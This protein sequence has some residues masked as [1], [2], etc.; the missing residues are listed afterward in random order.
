MAIILIVTDNSLRVVTEVHYPH[1]LWFFA[2]DE[3]LVNIMR[4][5][6]K[7]ENKTKGIRKTKDGHR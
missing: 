5:K 6:L 7:G 1:L 2:F 4:N 3:K